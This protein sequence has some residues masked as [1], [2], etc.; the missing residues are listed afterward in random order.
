[1]WK[2]TWHSVT[3]ASAACLL[4]TNAGCSANKTVQKG[5]DE[6]LKISETKVVDAGKALQGGPAQK[7]DTTPPKTPPK[8]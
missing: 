4:L 8:K 2:L 7:K 5:K 1:M 6:N 3:M